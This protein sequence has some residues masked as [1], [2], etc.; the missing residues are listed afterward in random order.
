MPVTKSAKKALSQSLKR[1]EVN[2]KY[3]TDMKVAT[4]VFL[5]KIEKGEKLKETDLST[6]YAKID[7]AQ[8]K[9]L[10]HKKTAARRK[11]LVARRF[12]ATKTK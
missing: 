5:K 2:Q 12:N 3:K 1:R 10:L 7:K 4:K 6:V 8:K 9:N 11:A